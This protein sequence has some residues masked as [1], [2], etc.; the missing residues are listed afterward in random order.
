MDLLTCQSL[1]AALLR[2]DA[3]VVR[4][5]HN[6]CHFQIGHEPCTI[7][8][9]S[10]AKGDSRIA[11]ALADVVVHAS[12]VVQTCETGGSN[13]FSENWSVDVS[14]YGIKG[15]NELTVDGE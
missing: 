8:L 5:W 12:E 10:S 2:G 9:K 13:A 3:Y 4:K 15:S 1:F 6:G 7:K 14:R 11:I